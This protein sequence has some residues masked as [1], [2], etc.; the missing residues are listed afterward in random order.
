M[1]CIRIGSGFICG[2]KVY[3]FNGYY[4]EW[5][6]YCGPSPLRKDGELSQRTPKGFWDM[7]EE[8]QALSSEEKEKYRI[9]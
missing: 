1:P 2:P 9:N 4:F 3:R 7:V 8:F 5:H 6:N